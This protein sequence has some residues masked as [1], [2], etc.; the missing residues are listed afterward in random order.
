MSSF[1]SDFLSSFVCLFASYFLLLLLIE[2]FVNRLQR[3][4]VY[5]QFTPKLKH[6]F[7]NLALSS[8]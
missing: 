4:L 6:V 7:S 2:L 1:V 3:I 5:T 8:V